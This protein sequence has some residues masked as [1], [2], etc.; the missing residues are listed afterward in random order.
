MSVN[1]GNKEKI[2]GIYK[3]TNKVNDKV[4]IGQS[5]DIYKRWDAHINT[6]NDKNKKEYNYPLYSAFRKYGIENFDFEILEVCDKETLDDLEI[7]YI[8]E[9]NSCT[10]DK[11]GYG[12]NQNHGGKNGYHENKITEEKEKIRIKKL[13]KSMKGENNPM[14]GKHHSDEVRKIISDF[15]KNNQTCKT[16]NVICDNI[17]FLNVVKC[18]EYYGV[19]HTT[20]TGWLTQKNKMPEKFINLNLH[21]K[22]SPDIQYKKIE[23]RT[24]GKSHMAKKVICD[25]MLFGSILECA[26]YYGIKSTMITDW[27]RGKCKMKKEFIDKNLHI[28]TEEEIIN[29]NG[30][31]HN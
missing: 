7:K 11:N 31:I 10:L 14:F 15:R 6:S 26:D 19:K 13:K 25:N 16:R 2:C 29:F 17:E 28:A 30:I 18:A 9:Y 21:Y 20:M 3:I 22:D 4:Y 24:K 23:K 8:K 27:F 12:Y 1:K 5:V